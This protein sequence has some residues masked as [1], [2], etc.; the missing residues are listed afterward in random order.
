MK[1]F[2]ATIIRVLLLLFVAIGLSCNEEE[3]EDFVNNENT[4]YYGNWKRNGVETWVK[5]SG[6]TAVT[7]NNGVQ[8]TGSFDAS[9][10]SMTFIIEGETIT[11]PLEFNGD[12]MWMGVPG[13][14]VDTN[15]AARYSRTDTFCE[16]GGGGGDGNG[17]ITF[18]LQSDLGCGPISVTL[19][20]QGSGTI[21]DYYSSSPSCGASGCANFT[22]PPGT[23]SFSASCDGHTWD[24]TVTVSANQCFKMQLY[25]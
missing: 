16:E 17:Q 21:T 5:F 25:N 19:H 15:V 7:C 8:T 14:Y 20:N 2:N 4:D 18:W 23:Y 12:T 24:S 11:F 13:A 10:P 1:K 6:S 3:P 22:V 9:E